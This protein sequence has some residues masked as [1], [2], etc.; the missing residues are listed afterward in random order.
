MTAPL[1]RIV[2][3]L[4][5]PLRRT[6]TLPLT[7]GAGRGVRG[8]ARLRVGL[9]PRMQWHPRACRARVELVSVAPLAVP[10]PVRRAGWWSMPP[11]AAGRAK[12]R[13][14]DPRHRERR[15]PSGECEGDAR[16]ALETTTAAAVAAHARAL[17]AVLVGSAA[18][19]PQHQARAAIR[20][21]VS[22]SARFPRAP[23]TTAPLHGFPRRPGRRPWRRCWAGSC[24]R[25]RW[26]A[27]RTV[28]LVNASFGLYRARRR[29]GG[30]RAG[31]AQPAGRRWGGAADPP[32]PPPPA[33]IRLQAAAPE[34]PAQERV[35]TSSG[36]SRRQQPPAARA[37]GAPEA[38]S[39][40][41]PAGWSG[42]CS[43]PRPG[44]A[45]RAGP[46]GALGRPARP[47]PSSA[48]SSAARRSSPAGAGG[49]PRR[50]GGHR[51]RDR[52]D[53]PAAGVR[54]GLGTPVA[55]GPAG[56]HEP[57]AALR[58]PFRHR[59]PPRG[60]GP[61][62]LCRGG[63]ATSS[64]SPATSPSAPGPPSSRRR[65][66]SWRGCRPARGWW[67][68][69]TM[70]CPVRPVVLL[71]APHGGFRRCFGDERMRRWTPPGC[72]RWW[73]APAA[74]V[75]RQGALASAQI[76]AV[77]R[78][79]AGRAR[80]AAA[81]GGGPSPAGCGPT[82]RTRRTSS[83]APGRRWGLVRRGGSGV[84]RARSCALCRPLAGRHGPAARG[85]AVLAGSALST[86]LRGGHPN[87]KEPDSATRVGWTVS[88]AAGWNAT[89]GDE[90]GR[91][92]FRLAG[93]QVVVPGG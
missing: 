55:A 80:G 79:C 38:E 69:A 9:D 19:A 84:V 3:R 87:S 5:R 22:S 74:G 36:R 8:P 32:R 61:A 86:R 54:R 75:I 72:W 43:A 15:R 49:G 47:T 23:S 27:Q 93:A 44:R 11:L 1:R 66:T 14:A 21:P 41:R 91:A 13:G 70:T 77:S 17:G 29:P 62:R 34:A 52:P 4:I 42:W 76:E 89:T 46:Q 56:R 90:G 16:D 35:L 57:P 40:W 48:W 73:T 53:A 7:G 68:P 60:G 51:R 88:G 2:Q 31:G 82:R 81:G 24:G 92:E 59:A 28:F 12:A 63:G 50:G 71:W 78:A 18:T 67:C 85:W 45:V 83:A 6:G 10:P 33:P 37:G 64:W 26:A 65:P 30:L 39:R 58:S 20:P 25:C